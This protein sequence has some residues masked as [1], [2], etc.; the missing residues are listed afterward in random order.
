[1]PK[2]ATQDNEIQKCFAVMHELRPHLQESEFVERVKS[3]Q[4]DGYQL[5]FLESDGEVVSV[6]GFRIAT[7]LAM[8]KYLY[9]DDLVT[10]EKARSNGYGEVMLSWL[11]LVAR[12]NACDVLHL[13]SGTHRKQAHKFYFRE[14]LTISSF[15]FDMQL[16]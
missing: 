16:S 7:N 3:M 2:L 6:A 11:K 15:H 12:D 5:A 4:A 10:A 1:M 8:G 9:V 14:G 13:D